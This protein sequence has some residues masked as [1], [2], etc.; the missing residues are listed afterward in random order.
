LTVQFTS[1]G[2]TYD[3][4]AVATATYASAWW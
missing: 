4:A 3:P 2:G 1:L